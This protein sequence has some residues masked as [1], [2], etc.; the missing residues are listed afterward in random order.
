MADK[1][2]TAGGHGYIGHIKNSGSQKVEAPFKTENKA[3][4]T[5]HKGSDLRSGK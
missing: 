2:P 4:S 1:K 5:V 3:K